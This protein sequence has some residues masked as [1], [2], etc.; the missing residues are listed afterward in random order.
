MITMH[1]STNP[2]DIPADAVA[3]AGY[4]DGI[5]AWPAS[6][7]ARFPNA[8]KV[9]IAVSAATVGAD[10]YDVETGD[11]TP[12]QCPVVSQRER[13]AKRDPVMYVNRTNWPAV[14]AC[15]TAA[16]VALPRFWVATLDCVESMV[17]GAVATQWA[18]ERCAGGHFDLSLV[19]PAWFAVSSG[20]DDMWTDQE[21]AQ[22][23][24]ALKWLQATL[25]G[26]PNIQGQGVLKDLQARVARIE[27]ALTQA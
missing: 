15:Y 25:W 16:R 23:L 13:A 3:V 27:K 17:P 24:D 5:Y 21:K 6:G 9:R 22:A 18:G 26:D 12:P 7:W 4:V 8:H 14:I 11:L 1:D 20:A 2:F 19:D 10:A